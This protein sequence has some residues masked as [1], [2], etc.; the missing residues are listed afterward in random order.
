MSRRVELTIPV[1]VAAPAADVWHAI[2]DW[3]GQ[4]EWIFATTVRVTVPGDGRRLGATLSAVTGFGPLAFTDNM[5]I[6]EWEP[7]RRCVVLHTGKIIRGDGVFE[8][9]ELGPE[10]SRVLWTERLDLPFG[11]IGLAGWTLGRGL[12]RAG[13]ASSLRK[14]A[15]LCENEYRTGG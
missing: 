2:T 8:V 14:M 9:E 7:P 4:S 6:S 1:E 11:V 15:R 12:F 3:P 10:R 13:V 5:E